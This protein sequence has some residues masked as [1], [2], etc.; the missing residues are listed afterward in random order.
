MIPLVL[1]LL[2]GNGYFSHHLYLTSVNQ[3][4]LHSHAERGNEG[5]KERVVKLIF[6][7]MIIYLYIA[8]CMECATC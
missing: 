1:M 8:C 6:I 5:T 2:R 7:I 4:A 3:V